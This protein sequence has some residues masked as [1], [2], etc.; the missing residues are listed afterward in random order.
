MPQLLRSFSAVL[1]WVVPVLAGCASA[2]SEGLAQSGTKNARALTAKLPP[3]YRQLM[4]QYVRATWISSFPIRGGKISQ[5]HARPAGLFS[6]SVVPAVCAILFR[7]NPLGQ[8]V[9]ENYVM[10]IAD[11]RVR[12][13]P[14]IDLESCP[15]FSTFHE[16]L[17]R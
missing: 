16:V 13:L 17:R 12:Q 5:P 8:T 2:P 7:D 14:T 3:N 4:A 6:S 9:S 15:G 11:G 10:T 1:L